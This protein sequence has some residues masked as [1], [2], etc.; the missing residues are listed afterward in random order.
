VNT[1]KFNEL[2]ENLLSNLLEKKLS[3][4]SY[5]FN[6]IRAGQL[7]GNERERRVWEIGFKEGE[8]LSGGDLLD[9]LSDRTGLNVSAL[10]RVLDKLENMGVVETAS[11]SEGEAP[12]DI[13]RFDDD[14]EGMNP[15]EAA[16]DYLRGDY[17]DEG[18]SEYNFESL[19]EAKKSY[20]AKQASKGKDI[21]KKG[22]M[23]GKIAKSAGKKY[24]SKE[25]GKKVAGAILK[26]LRQK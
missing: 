21:G 20:S 13:E 16:D 4:V 1:P 2:L 12:D 25:A 24:G 5:I 26:K 23:F 3:D 15:D 8:G 22:K 17:E 9:L 7:D 14:D 6:D 19:Q 10:L 11:T 18:D